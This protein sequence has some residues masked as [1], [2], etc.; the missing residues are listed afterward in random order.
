MPT[1]VQYCGLGLR[2]DVIYQ[3]TPIRDKP[4]VLGRDGLG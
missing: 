1:H 4:Y 2:N 3:Y